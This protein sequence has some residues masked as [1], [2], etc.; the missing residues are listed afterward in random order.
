MSYTIWNFLHSSALLFNILSE[1]KKDIYLNYILSE[2]IHI[3]PCETCKRNYNEI[4]LDILKSNTVSN[5]YQMFDITVK[6]HNKINEK[7]HSPTYATEVAINM[8]ATKI[9]DNIYDLIHPMESS[10]WDCFI[11]CARFFNNKSDIVFDIIIKFFKTVIYLFYLPTMDSN[12]LF[13]ILKTDIITNSIDFCHQVRAL[14][15]MHPYA[16][17]TLKYDN[18]D[19]FNKMS[20]EMNL[21]NIDFVTV[22]QEDSSYIILDD[23]NIILN[24]N[25]KSYTQIQPIEMPN[26]IYENSDSNVINNYNLIT[27]QNEETKQNLIIIEH[28]DS[29]Y[30][31]SVFID[32]ICIW[33]TIIQ[34]YQKYI[35]YNNLDEI[36]QHTIDYFSYLVNSSYNVNI[37][38]FTYEIISYDQYDSIV[39]NNS[40]SI[41]KDIFIKN[42]TFLKYD[43]INYKFELFDI[44]QEIYK[45]DITVELIISKSLN[46]IEFLQTLLKNKTNNSNYFLRHSDGIINEFISNSNLQKILRLEIT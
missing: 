38:L 43:N 42:T 11:Y 34:P 24:N 10:V 36:E 20:L 39:K 15:Y 31:Q 6:I 18:I 21:L 14:F 9:N 45:Y 44:T 26:I 41:L 12:F 22:T 30:W 23:T 4:L 3:L 28:T 19:L 46:I 33:N 27:K 7:L 40:T 29:S 5:S 2:I 32:S 37:H 25:V 16:S 8:Y 35:L 17:I 13:S 1:E